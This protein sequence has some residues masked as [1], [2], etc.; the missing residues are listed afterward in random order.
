MNIKLL[1]AMA[2]VGGWDAFISNPHYVPRKPKSRCC[3]NPS[4]KIYNDTF[5]R[6]DFDAVLNRNPRQKLMKAA[7]RNVLNIE[8]SIT[9]VLHPPGSFGEIID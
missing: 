6:A 8:M 7:R 1:A 3:S 2:A 4:C 5:T 9:P